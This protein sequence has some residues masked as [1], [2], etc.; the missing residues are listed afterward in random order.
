[1]R[2][3]IFVLPLAAPEDD[4]RQVVALRGFVNNVEFLRAHFVVNNVFC[5]RPPLADYSL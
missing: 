4:L 1:M 2:V 5:R 3:I